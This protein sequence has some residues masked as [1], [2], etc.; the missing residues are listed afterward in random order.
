MPWIKA[1]YRA[2]GTASTR[3]HKVSM[4]GHKGNDGDD[5]L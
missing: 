4:G 3:F 1:N 2:M 5:R